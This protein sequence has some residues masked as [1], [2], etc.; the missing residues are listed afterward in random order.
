[1]NLPIPGPFQKI[2]QRF[3][4]AVEFDTGHQVTPVNK[5]GRVEISSAG[6]VFVNERIDPANV[7]FR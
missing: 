4:G 6:P 3:L 7:G 1:M 5:S 2:V